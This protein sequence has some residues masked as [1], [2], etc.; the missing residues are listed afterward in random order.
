MDLDGRV[1]RAVADV[2]GGDVGT[3]T[4][5]EYHQDGDLVWASYSGGSIRLGHLVGTRDGDT[6]DFRYSQLTTDGR[7]DAGHC[8]ARV[9]ALPDGRLRLHEEWRW[10]SREGSGTSIV[11]SEPVR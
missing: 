6:L 11:E 4:V 7:T 9:E 10:E 2:V 8:L 1:F 3:D 5:F